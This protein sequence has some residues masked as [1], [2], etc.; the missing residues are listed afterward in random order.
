MMISPCEPRQFSRHRQSSSCDVA[1]TDLVQI[2]A[3]FY[4]GQ[5]FRT[6]FRGL[7]IAGGVVLVVAEPGGQLV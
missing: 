4:F 1:G 2:R 7:M 6:Y 5:L 3:L